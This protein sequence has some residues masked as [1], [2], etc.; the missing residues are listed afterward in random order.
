MKESVNIFKIL[1]IVGGIRTDTQFILLMH[2]VNLYNWPPKLLQFLEICFT[3]LGHLNCHWPRNVLLK[4][5]AIFTQSLWNLVK[6]TY[7]W[8][9]KIARI[10]TCLGQNCGIFINTKFLGQW[11]FKCHTWYILFNSWQYYLKL[12][13]PIDR[14]RC[15]KFQI[16]LIPE[17]HSAAEPKIETDTLNWSQF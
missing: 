16:V 5:S 17:L 8:I 1:Y 6:I 9:G 11:R 14:Y 7:P 15:K 2:W 3:G 10:K 4:K 12:K 13:L